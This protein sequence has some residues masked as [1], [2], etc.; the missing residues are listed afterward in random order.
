MCKLSLVDSIFN[1]VKFIT[2]LFLQETSV[3]NIKQRLK[4]GIFLEK[5]S[6]KWGTFRQSNSFFSITKIPGYTCAT[7]F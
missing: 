1:L 6:V 7:F 2:D 4:E 5:L 3:F